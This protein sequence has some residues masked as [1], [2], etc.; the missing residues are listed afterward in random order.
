LYHVDTKVLNQA[1]KRNLNRFPLSF[2]FQLVDIEKNELVTNCDRLEKLKHSTSNP[3][4]F[5]EQGAAILSAVDQF[6]AE[7][8]KKWFAFSKM[9]MGSME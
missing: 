6:G 9:D 8:G 7:L 5:T 1:V 2:R 4:A 3:Y